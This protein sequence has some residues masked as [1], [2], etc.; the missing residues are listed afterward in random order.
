MLQNYN[1]Y[2]I[3]EL[4]FDYPTKYFQMREISRLTGLALP[5]VINHLK[6]LEKESFV[7]KEKTNIYFSYRANKI[8]KFR[9]YKKMNLLLR[10]NDSGLV[11][12]LEE[13]LSPNV[14][15]LFGSS[16]KG[17]DIENS[18]VDIFILAKEE[19]LNLN[20][21]EKKL[22]RKINLFFEEKVKEIPLE[23]M[24]NIINGIVLSGYLKVLK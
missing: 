4:F 16:S 6:K 8:K 14:I 10:L 13:K 23:L 24:N 20:L 11:E 18:D 1:T 15:V 12:F 22:K 3:L 5:S 21:Y 17:E 9:L 7:K 2:K 19:E